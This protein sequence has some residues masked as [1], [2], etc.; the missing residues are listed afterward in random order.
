MLDTSNVHRCGC[1]V[2]GSYGYLLYLMKRP[3]DAR[4]YLDLALAKYS[5]HFNFWNYCYYGL[6]EY[7]QGNTAKSDYYSYA[8][9]KFCN[10]SHLKHL[11]D[12]KLQDPNNIEYILKCERLV[13]KSK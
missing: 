11:G 6:L 10:E 3:D 12:M 8:F 1:N 9:G 2:Y 4:K 5:V 7:D 13:T